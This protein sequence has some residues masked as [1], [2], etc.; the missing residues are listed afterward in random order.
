MNF[1]LYNTTTSSLIA[2]RRAFLSTNASQPNFPTLKLATPNS[3]SLASLKEP[4]Q[5]HQSI[6]SPNDSQYDIRPSFPNRPNTSTLSALTIKENERFSYQHNS[7]ISAN[8]ALSPKKSSLVRMPSEKD[9]DSIIHKLEIVSSNKNTGNR[10]LILSESKSLE[11][12]LEKG[13]VQYFTVT[14]FN[15]KPP[16]VVSIKRNKGRVAGYASKFNYEPSKTSYDACLQKD[17]MLVSELN[18]RFKNDYIFL[19]FEAITDAEFVVSAMFGAKI[20][21]RKLDANAL[22]IELLADEPLMQQNTERMQKSAS[23][24]FISINKLSSKEKLTA[25]VLSARH[26]QWQ[27]RREA[28]V[29]NRNR[30]LTLKRQKTMTFLNKNEIKR[31]NEKREKEAAEKIAIRESIIRK[32]MGLFCFIRTVGEIRNIVQRSREVK[33]ERIKRNMQV[34][35]IQKNYKMS[36]KV[37][38]DQ[39]AILRASNLLLLF[40]GNSYPLSEFQILSSI[41]NSYSS[42]KVFYKFNECIQKVLLIQKN[43]REYAQRM[44]MIW[45]GLLRQW[46]AVL[47]EKMLK[48]SRSNTKRSRERESRKFV[49]ISS[50]AKTEVLKQYFKDCKLKYLRDVKDYYM[51]KNLLRD[52]VLRR[53]PLDEEMKEKLEEG[54]RIKFEVKPSREEIM[55]LIERGIKFSKDSAGL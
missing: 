47:E 1:S 10:R 55:K 22:R 52:N 23:K 45:E 6:I 7:L 3:Q 20:P 48:L 36:T 12:L 24:D 17:M 5:L 21:R 54:R 8:L 30:Q 28:A 2:R 38:A 51:S 50:N 25:E 4:P 39:V 19:A 42:Y 34:K 31:E 35:R 18:I 13:A 14:C 26:N 43:W 16:L 49:A 15:K 40:R 44:K 27:L 9:F 11:V 46:N 32:W 33:L 41:K 37:D 53:L 29:E